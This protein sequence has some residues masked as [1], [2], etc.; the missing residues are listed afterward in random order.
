[1]VK[2]EA[3]LEKKLAAFRKFAGQERAEYPGRLKPVQ[4][5]AIARALEAHKPVVQPEEV[6]PSLKDYNGERL[7]WTTL[8]Q[9]KWREQFRI[10][11]HDC[12]HT[13][14][15]PVTGPKPKAVASTEPVTKKTYEEAVWNSFC[16][17]PDTS[18]FFIPK[19]RK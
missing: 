19:L 4:Y 11:L 2:T 3:Q 8:A 17:R 9:P 5:M 14:A 16:G 7:H 10:W 18:G 13:H 1:M 12:R 6:L 15:K